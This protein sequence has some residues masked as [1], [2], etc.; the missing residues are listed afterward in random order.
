MNVTIEELMTTQVMTITK[1]VT[2]GHVADL[3]REHKVSAL[4]VVGPDDEPLGMVTSSDLL[5]GHPDAAPVSSF[6]SAPAYTVPLNEGPHVAA[7]IMRNH[8]LHH[9]VVVDDHKVVGIVSAYDLLRLVED[10][11][12]VAKQAPTPSRKQPNRR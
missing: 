7:R 9:V 2:A 1:H 10:H 5:A 3:M 8:R 12:Y 4:P 6:M 11:R